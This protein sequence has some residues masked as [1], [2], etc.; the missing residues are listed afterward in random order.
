MIGTRGI[1]GKQV[2]FRKYGDK[3]V[4]ASPPDFSDRVLSP[5]QVR[6]TETMSR[7]NSYAKE[8]LKD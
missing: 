4:V 3:T 1:L 6:N 5:K 8:V 2:V 7:A